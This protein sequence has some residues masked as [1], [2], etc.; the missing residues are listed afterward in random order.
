[1]SRKKGG[2]R[3]GRP[4]FAFYFDRRKDTV[5]SSLCSL[6]CT[7]GRTRK[8][9]TK[10]KKEENEGISSNAR[11]LEGTY[12]SFVC[13]GGKKRGVGKSEKGGSNNGLVCLG[14]KKGK[15]GAN[16]FV[17]AKEG[18]KEITGGRGE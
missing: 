4:W 5:C 10:G 15:M 8:P 12:V 11:F 2:A 3:G 14:E 17:M 13:G 7:K 16:H 1:L 6:Q 18:S 9:V